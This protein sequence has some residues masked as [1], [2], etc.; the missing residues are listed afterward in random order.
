[1]DSLREEDWT[2]LIERIEDGDCTP[3]L[4]S[5]IS[6]EKIPAAR[7]M[8]NELQLEAQCTV[9]E[10]D[11]LVQVAQAA[12]LKYDPVWPKRKV[13]KKWFE[14]TAP[15]DPNDATEPHNVL[16]VLPFPIY[17]TT[18]YDHFMVAALQDDR[19]KKK[20]IQEYCRWND[21]LKQQ[22][23]VLT[24]DMLPTKVEPLVYHLHGHYQL[25]ESMVLTEDDYLDF[26]V[27]L[28]SGME[29]P[30]PSSSRLEEVPF[31]PMPIQNALC[32]TSLM[33]IGYSLADWDF[34][35]LLRGLL[36]KV[37]KGMQYMS[38]TVQ[39][40]QGTEEERAQLVKYFSREL[41]PE[42]RFYWGKARDFAAELQKRWMTRAG[43]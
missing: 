41:G 17:I 38:V 18:N 31:L 8:A 19:K 14:G 40:E 25:L 27:G 9:K 29:R 11:D 26:L 37:T 39:L 23:P 33:L 2:T 20:P 5:G 22:K 6:A 35:V 21:F 4:G 30:S 28:S 7:R 13:V 36:T 10:K 32:R 15:P 3:F 42:L 12:A 43:G 16:A 34:R 1:M 24:R